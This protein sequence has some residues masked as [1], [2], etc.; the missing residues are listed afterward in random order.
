MEMP[1]LTDSD[2]KVHLFP[3][4]AANR[5]RGYVWVEWMTDEGLLTRALTYETC[6]TAYLNSPGGLYH[7][8]SKYG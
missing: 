1:I 2:L 7:S 8:A 4:G 5:G 3:G 6:D